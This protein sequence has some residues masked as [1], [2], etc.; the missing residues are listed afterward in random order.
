M[1]IKNA[2]NIIKDNY[3]EYIKYT[4]E[5][6]NYPSIIDG[7][8][9]SH[10]RCIH[11]IYTECPKHFVK[12]ATAIG[13]VVKAHPHP[14]SIYSTLVPLTQKDS[15]FPIFDGQGNF[16]ST[17]PQSEPAAERYTE[18]KISDLSS[19]IFESFSNF[20]DT[21]EGDLNNIEPQA[22]ATFLP[23]SLIHGTYSIPV[24]MSTVDTP[25]L[26]ALDLCDYAIEVLKSGD[27]NTV[28]DVFIRPNLGNV[29]IKSSRK[30]WKSMLM[31]GYGK[32][33]IAPKINIIDSKKLEIVALPESKSIDHI[34][35]ILE[36]EILRDVIDVI[37]ETTTTLNIIVEIRPHKQVKIDDLA[38]RLTSKL[39]VNKNYRFIYSD[40]SGAAVHCG[41]STNMR[42]CLEYLIKCA[43][44]WA[45]KS[46]SDL[47]Y[48]LSIL[49]V[50][51]QL[52]N[53]EEA[54]QTLVKSTKASAVNFLIDK[55]NINKEQAN[56][57]LSKPISYLTS[58]HSSELREIKTELK[59][60]KKIKDDIYTYLVNK[61]TE[62]K[63]EITK[64]IMKNRVTT[65]FTRDKKLSNLIV[66]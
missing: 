12:S 31:N 17:I 9:P 45:E 42:Y 8:K 28:P 33:Q 41:V 16:G 24:G 60:F 11:Q 7:C 25:A 51:E 20:V 3:A 14:S 4:T 44:R 59:Q 64:T 5:F 49:E 66:M 34:N 27:I 56:S 13:A 1:T 62:L 6:R 35:K 32:V 23:L 65:T 43:I 19:K 18:I 39:T 63:R 36:N 22:L 40:I 53:D 58:E 47:Q 26:N 48:K 50:L 57:V 52:R 37:D 55:Y 30:D 2:N 46:V 15:P 38:K 61:Y 54:L 21:V 29:Q 10:R